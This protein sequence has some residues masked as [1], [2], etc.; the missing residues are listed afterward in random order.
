VREPQ[1]H[2]HPSTGGMARRVTSPLVRA[3]GRRVSGQQLAPQAEPDFSRE[4][5]RAQGTHNLRPPQ[6]QQGADQMK[7][8]GSMFTALWHYTVPPYVQGPVFALERD[9]NLGETREPGVRVSQWEFSTAPEQYR[10]RMGWWWLTPGQRVF[11]LVMGRHPAHADQTL[12]HV[13]P[14]RYTLATVD[15]FQGSD[16]GDRNRF[17]EWIVELDGIEVDIR[18]G[19]LGIVRREW[20]VFS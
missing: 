20:H 4:Q 9:P 19:R 17:F 7:D 15:W 5:K 3:E 13:P 12:Y 11:G 14:S 8:V 2:T 18:G 6:Q 1:T 16:R 10:L